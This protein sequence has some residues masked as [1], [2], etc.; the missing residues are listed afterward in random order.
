MKI[1]NIIALSFAS[2]ALAFGAVSTQSF[3]QKEEAQ[4]VYA[5]KSGQT[6]SVATSYYS[7]C[8]GLTGSSLKT[9]L[10]KF[11]KPKNTSYDWSRYEAADEAQDD[12]SSILCLYTRHNIG[13]SSHCGSYAWDKWNREHVF[14]QSAFPASDT[15]NHNIFACEGQINNYRGNLKFDEGGNIVTV[16]GHVTECKLNSGTSF[17]PC[18]AAKGEVARAVMYCCIYYGYSITDIFVSASVAVK[19]HAEHPVTDREIY[20]NNIVYGLQGNRNPFIDHP[21]YANSIFG[22]NYLEPDP[23]NDTKPEDVV[24]VTSV[25]LNKT[26]DSIYVGDTSTLTATISPSDATYKTVSWSSSDSTVASVSNSG[27]VTGVKAGTATITATSTDGN[28]TATC[29]VTVNAR[30]VTGVSLN[31]SSLELYEG[32]TS[33]LIATVSPSNATNKK[34]SWSSSDSTVA[35]VNT[36]GLVTAVKKGSATITVTT[37]D[38]GKTATCNVEVS[39]K[40][41]TTISVESVSLNKSSLELE[42]GNTSTLVETILPSNATNKNVTWSTNNASVAT[43]NNGVVTAVAEGNAVITVTTVD[44]NK[45][46]TC[47]VTVSAKQSGGDT[48]TPQPEPPEPT[49]GNLVRIR[50]ASRPN[51]LEYA[52]GEKLDLTGMVIVAVYDNN[53]TKDVTSLVKVTEPN[54]NKAGEV[55]VKISYTEGE[56]TAEIN[57]MVTITSS[58]A[59]SG[60]SGSIIASSV[61][62][63][64]TSL[65]GAGLLMFKK[66]KD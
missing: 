50:L 28:K 61:I 4:Q 12:S 29:A 26:S 31:K 2:F 44:G 9:Q 42:E 58:V 1:K 22:A 49:Y 46:A 24:H 8:D 39:E 66:K 3:I 60:C 13:K 43:V 23:L 56:I 25:S 30:P 45:T 32:D 47:A 38:G 10:A 21:S 36:N 11:N 15:D 18:D 33:T 57:F 19:W 41:V 20:R 37:E 14:T 48:P 17:E 51:K 35:S 54:M 63:S 55:P 6:P 34:V 40:P 16:F 64:L 59:S 5:W 27:V 62:I 7:S 53:L 65:L 52:G